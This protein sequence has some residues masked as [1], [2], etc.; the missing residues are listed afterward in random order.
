MD[1]DLPID[2]VME[3]GHISGFQIFMSCR[4]L[5]C[6]KYAATISKAILADG[7]EGDA[8]GRIWSALTF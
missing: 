5:W 8:E 1:L 6:P 3:L 7:K 2:S 4:S